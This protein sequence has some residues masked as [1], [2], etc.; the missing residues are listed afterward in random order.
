MS[1]SVPAKIKTYEIRDALRAEMRC[2]PSKPSTIQKST[3]AEKR[4]RLLGR[5]NKFNQNAHWFVSGI[6]FND[7][8]LCNHDSPFCSEEI[9]DDI[10]EAEE[11]QFWKGYGEDEGYEDMEGT[12]MEVNPEDMKVS[13]P[14]ALQKILDDGHGLG[15]QEIIKEELQLRV[16]QANDCLEKLRLHLGNKA[17]LYRMS[18]RSSS[19]VRTDT[20]T[21]QEIRRV[22]HKINQDARGYIRA[23]NA[24]ISLKAPDD[25]LDK[26]K[27][28][29]PSDLGVSKD[30]TE[31]NRF[32]QSSDVL[33]WFWRVGG[34]SDGTKSSIQ[35][36]E[37]CK[38]SEL[39]SIIN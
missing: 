16:G 10:E 31:E 2:M 34:I 5:I 25:I 22:V 23:H 27:I 35:W 28:I 29:H 8:K 14:S 19:S 30:I 32:G 20:R 39:H 21:K 26:Y 7:S 6:E 15:L 38:L 13:M 24:L 12:L 37:E 17:V 11:E 18:F 9:G 36:S 33:P 1:F 4:K 3:I